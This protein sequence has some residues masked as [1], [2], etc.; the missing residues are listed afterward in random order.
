MRPGGRGHAPGEMGVAGPEKSEERAAPAGDV[1]RQETVVAVVAV[2]ETA[3]LAAAHL[4]VRQVDGQDEPRR[5]L[6]LDGDRA[7]RRSVPFRLCRDWEQRAE[8]KP[9]VSERC[10]RFRSS[11]KDSRP[12][13]STLGW[14]VR[15]SSSHR[16][17]GSAATPTQYGLRWR[18]DADRPFVHGLTEQLPSETV[19]ERRSTSR[20][21]NTN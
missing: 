20:S 10:G 8:M 5:R 3:L 14:P 21:G 7:N 15:G 16:V 12:P 9:V 11:I 4:V 1:Q 18:E 17:G 19:R 6:A 13:A 2:D